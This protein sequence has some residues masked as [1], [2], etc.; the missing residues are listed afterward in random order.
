MQVTFGD[1]RFGFTLAREESG[2]NKGKGV[3]CKVHL[4]TTAQ[5]LGVKV[6]DIVTGVNKRR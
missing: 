5:T 1:G 3:V 2:K 6:G 4:H